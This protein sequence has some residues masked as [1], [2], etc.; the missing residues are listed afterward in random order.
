MSGIKFKQSTL[1]RTD[2][3][4]WFLLIL[5]LLLL[6]LSRL[7]PF[8]RIVF[9]CWLTQLWRSQWQFP[10]I[11]LKIRSLATYHTVYNSA[12]S[13]MRSQSAV[14]LCRQ[15]AVL[16]YKQALGYFPILCHS[17][18]IQRSAGC[19]VRAGNAGFIKR[20]R[21]GH[22]GS[23]ALRDHHKSKAWRGFIGL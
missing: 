2:Y 11:E 9:K 1:W 18:S 15:I 22:G 6:L 17:C 21:G 14:L 13:S 5:L 10:N 8:Q 20:G 4:I 23:P 16:M 12:I 7:K 3:L 19:H